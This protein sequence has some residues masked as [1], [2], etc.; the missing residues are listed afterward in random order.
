MTVQGKA[1]GKLFL[2]GEYAVV[3]AGN[4]AMIAAIDRY[5]TVTVTEEAKGSLY[6]SQQ[7]DVDIFWERVGETIVTDVE[8]PYALITSAM[9]I[10]ERYAR[11]NGRLTQSVYRLAVDSDL[12]DEAS[13][14][15]YGLGSSG[16]VTVATVRAI[17]AFYDLP[18]PAY[19]VYQL[20]VLTQ[21]QLEKTGSFGDIAVSAYGGV[22]YYTS[23]DR[24]WLKQ[25][26]AQTYLPDLLAMSWKDLTIEP[27]EL[28]S[29]LK[30]LVGWTGRAALTDHLIGQVKE[31]RSQLEIDHLHQAFLKQS[32]E[33]VE[34]LYDACQENQP[35]LFQDKIRQNRR[36][37]ADF[38]RDMGLVIETETLTRLC[39]LAE[40]RGA[41]AK[42]SG[43]GAG[44]CGIC[45]VEEAHQEEM[46]A[47]SWQ[48][49]GILPLPFAIADR[50]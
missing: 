35:Q 30:L 2:A 36:I 20:A 4:P 38:A 13:K 45:F 42:T 41:A 44:D 26:L 40:A 21:L 27:V 25:H 18:A 43:A 28:P 32:R 14:T 48:E 6:S 9:E 39:E 34:N 10:T 22:V 8:N 23:P 5:L 3:D 47:T 11:A 12:D 24:A 15:K 46:I 16:A 29:S 33:C 37:L 17:L 19:L 1:P 31:K 49:A 7:P 50:Q